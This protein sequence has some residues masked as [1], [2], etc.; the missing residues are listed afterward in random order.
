MKDDSTLYEQTNGDVLVAYLMMKE[1]GGAN[2]P[3]A[4]IKRYHE[5]R[6]IL[7]KDIA[8]ILKKQDLRGYFTIREWTTKRN[9]ENFYRGIRALLELERSGITK[10]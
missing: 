9:K 4:W 5:S 3:T 7:E 6:K 10:L 8:R 1:S 2:V